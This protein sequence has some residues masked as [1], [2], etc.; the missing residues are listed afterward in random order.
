MIGEVKRFAAQPYGMLTL[1]GSWGNGK[2]LALMGLVNHFNGLQPGSACY[3]TFEEL[4]NV[5]RKGFKDGAEF[6]A[7]A[8]ALRLRQIKYLAIDEFDKANLTRFGETFR[9]EFFDYR[10]RDAKNGYSHTVLAMNCDIA[11]LPGHIYDRIHYGVRS[12]LGFRVVR[13]KDE[14]ARPSGLDL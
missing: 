14:S 7:E 6:D 4:M 13:N 9:S 3:M 10:Y 11:D 12:P 8:R 5:V 1:W 2:S